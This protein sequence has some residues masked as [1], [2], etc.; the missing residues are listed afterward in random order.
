MKFLSDYINDAQTK[1]LHKMGAFFAFSNEQVDEK[2]QDGVK[3]AHIAHG[4]IAPKENV[5]ALLDGLEEVHKE[6]VKLDLEEN[7][8]KGV[9]RRE[10]FNY[11]CFYTG[12]IEECVDSLSPYGISE[13][14]V[15][16]MYQH[17]R[18]TEDIDM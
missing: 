11:E 5:N 4:L 2:K 9:I 1:L 7:G 8:K 14:E 10:L 6:G 12:S 15:S 13:E 16:A 3:Y 18:A 17:I